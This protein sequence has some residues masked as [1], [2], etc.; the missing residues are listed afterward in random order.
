[1][2]FEYFLDVCC[3]SCS[4]NFQSNSYQGV[5]DIVRGHLHQAFN[6]CKVENM[7]ITLRTKERDLC[8]SF[9]SL[10]LPEQ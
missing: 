4:S 5:I 3:D 1:M 6:I 9:A 2:P 8:A 10:R 7:K